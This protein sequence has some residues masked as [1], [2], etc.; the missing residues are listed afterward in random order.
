MNDFLFLFLFLS[1][2]IFCNSQLI[3]G[4]T[5]KGKCVYIFNDSA[6]YNFHSL[7]SGS[8]EVKYQDIREEDGENNTKYTYGW[9]INLCNDTVVKECLNIT[10]NETATEST[11]A[12]YVER[13]NSQMVYRNQDYK[14][15]RGT[16]GYFEKNAGGLTYKES[17]TNFWFEYNAPEGDI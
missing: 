13:T 9:F 10:E 6:V 11:N 17:G 2:L 7:K 14:C 15:I 5:I 1:I 16:G 3:P 12:S 4:K 8:N